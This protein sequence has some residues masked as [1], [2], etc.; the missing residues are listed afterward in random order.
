MIYVYKYAYT[1]TTHVYNI[2]T[3]IINIFLIYLK[4]KLDQIIKIKRKKIIYLC[5][6]PYSRDG[7]YMII[8]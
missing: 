4:H 2:H 7:T 3:Y 1:H 6:A 8:M 5:H